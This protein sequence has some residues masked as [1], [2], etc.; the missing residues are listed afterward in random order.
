MK[1]GVEYLQKYMATYD[2]QP[3]YLDYSD[4]MLI[5]DVLYGLGVAVDDRKYSF[6][7]GFDAFKDFLMD[8]LR[9][10]A[11]FRNVAKRTTQP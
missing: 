1:A 11:K 3:G 8:M 7:N 9:R 2:K 4:D 5:K 6:A 10:D